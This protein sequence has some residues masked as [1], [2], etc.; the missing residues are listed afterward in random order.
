MARPL[1]ATINEDGSIQFLSPGMARSVKPPE[2]LDYAI[3][4][5][6]F[7]IRLRVRSRSPDQDGPARIFTVSADP[8]IRNVT[9][10][11]DSSDLVIRLRTPETSFNG[12]Q[13]P[14]DFSH[15][16]REWSSHLIYLTQYSVRSTR[17]KKWA[18]V[19]E[20]GGQ[21]GSISNAHR[22]FLFLRQPAVQAKESPPEAADP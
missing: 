2:W 6:K 19:A 21:S 13:R 17:S 3:R 7:S 5:N 10:A 1:A 16:G 11:Q 14:S 9:I 12:C 20:S 22:L 15:Y 8:C 4:L 18:G